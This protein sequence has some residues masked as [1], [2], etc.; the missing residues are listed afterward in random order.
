MKNKN[1][2]GSEKL[3]FR[4]IVLLHIKKILEIS[5]SEMRDKTIIRNQG[6]FTETIN[7]EDTRESYTQSIENLAY[8][9]MPYFDD[10][11][12]EVYNECIEIVNGL[13][14]EVVKILKKT[15]DRF[16]EDLKKSREEIE[17]DFVIAMKVRY[18]KKLF[19][20]LNLLLKRND[21]LKTAVYGEE[22][23][24]IAEDEEEDE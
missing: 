16:C 6:N 4:Q 17:H 14:F 9:L 19:I 20:A 2:Y 1:V 11:V 21:Y 3:E 8:I 5:N 23:D 12:K 15:L 24:E 22:Q 13:H 18:A 10:E 7:N